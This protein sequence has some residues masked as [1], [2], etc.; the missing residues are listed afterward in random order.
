[1][2]EKKAKRLAKLNDQEHCLNVRLN[3]MAEKKSNCPNKPND[4]EE[5]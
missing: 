2:A 3:Q 4:Q 5:V 1:M